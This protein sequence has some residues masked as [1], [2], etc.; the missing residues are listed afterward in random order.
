MWSSPLPF[1]SRM[2]IIK[3]LGNSWH[4]SLRVT[5]DSFEEQLS[6]FFRGYLCHHWWQFCHL[7]CY[8]MELNINVCPTLAIGRK[9]RKKK[10]KV[11][12][13]PL[14][15]WALEE[16]RSCHIYFLTRRCLK[17]LHVSPMLI[18]SAFH[19]LYFWDFCILNC[20]GNLNHLFSIK[21]LW[22]IT[23]S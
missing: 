16:N 10:C 1:A 13:H 21:N 14:S 4:L 17:V 12:I 19:F 11:I 8:R 23:V 20:R 5:F 18:R 9:R 3:S 15:Q 22:R 2:S 6:P 7:M